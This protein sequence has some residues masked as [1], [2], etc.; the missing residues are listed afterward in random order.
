MADAATAAVL[1]EHSRAFYRD[2]LGRLDDAGIDYL[3][4]GA[5]AFG[6]YTG[7]HRHT[8]DFDIFIRREDFERIAKVLGEAGYE[9]ELTFP[10]WL[11]K[12]FYGDDFIDLIFSAGN[13]VAK[14]DDQW[15]ERAVPGEVIGMDVRLI[16]AE[17]MIWSK[18]LIMER[19][20][21]D[22]A[23]VAHVIKAVGPQLDWRHLIDRYAENWRVL[24]A[25]LVLF[26]YI[27]PSHRSN[28]PAWVMDELGESVSQETRQPDAKEKICYGTVI[29]RQQYLKD[30]REWGYRDARLRPL[31]TM[32]AHDIA[33][34]TAG[35]AEDGAK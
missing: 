23:D 12:S 21:F 34:W 6:R 26:G 13:G 5:Y 30:I 20:R 14:V 28:I 19:E 27:Y 33:H 18:G 2:A 16:P 29:S 31:G 1:D 4:G 8:K 11:G 15:F 10:H 7:I 17:E 22:G 32:S 24:Y 35:I 3:V 25:H 9:S